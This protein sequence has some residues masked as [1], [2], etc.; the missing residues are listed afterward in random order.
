MKFDNDYTMSV[1][2]GAG[3]HSTLYK[4]DRSHYTKGSVYANN[5]EIAIIRPDSKFHRIKGQS[6]DV[7]GFVSA[8]KVIHIAYAVSCGDM[9]AVAEILKLQEEKMYV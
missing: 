4:V 1:C 7:V 8:D 9:D 6:D 5:A 3:T 2:I